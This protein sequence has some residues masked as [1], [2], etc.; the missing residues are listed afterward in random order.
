M[1]Y[2]ISEFPD[3]INIALNDTMFTH[4]YINYELLKTDR[5]MINAINMA[6]YNALKKC[7]EKNIQH[8]I[9]LISDNKK[10]YRNIIIKGIFSSFSNNHNSTGTH[11]LIE[12]IKEY[13]GK[14]NINTQDKKGNTLAIYSIIGPLNGDLPLL[15]FLV[16]YGA[17]LN[18]KNDRDKTVFDY[19]H[20]S[21]SITKYLKQ[22][23]KSE[24]YTP[25][26]FIN[27]NKGINYKF[28]KE[29][30]DS[31]YKDI[32]VINPLGNTVLMTLVQKVFNSNNRN[33]LALVNLL[34]SNGID[35]NYVNKKTGKT[36]LSLL[37]QH[38]DYELDYSSDKGQRDLS[39]IM[40]IFKMLLDNKVDPNKTNMNMNMRSYNDLKAQV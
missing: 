10:I 24:G 37:L 32:N 30:L 25:K 15:K 38:Y 28:V 13:I 20:K 4:P 39:I 9:K 26:E 33:L 23:K 36:A 14:K 22:F 21:V 19:S 6:P 8:G 7:M 18:I 3:F 40:G 5:D 1:L 2:N 16:D 17:D 27:A 31:G 35:I 34:I 11:V 29:I 12:M